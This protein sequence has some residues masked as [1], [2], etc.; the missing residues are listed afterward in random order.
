MSRWFAHAGARRTK[1]VEPVL[2]AR[3]R[4]ARS[5]V[6]VCL[7]ALGCPLLVAASAEAGQLGVFPRFA[8]AKAVEKDCAA[9]LGE[10]GVLQRQLA[11]GARLPANAGAD[12]AARHAAKLFGEMDR[13][14]QRAE[15][16]VAPLSLL[17]NVHPSKPLRDAAE[18]CELR[19]S[20]FS[21]RFYQDPKIYARIRQA[22]AGDDIDQRMRRDLLE[23]F[24]DSG[25]ALAPARR[26]RAR[27]LNNR[28]A[29]LSQ[30]FERRLRESSTRVAFTEAELQ[31]VPASVWRQAPRDRAGRRLL[32]LEYPSVMPVLENARDPLARERMWRA[33][34]ARGGEANLALLAQLAARRHEY[35]QL[36][37]LPSYADFALRHRMAG[38]VARAQGFLAEVRTVVEQRERRDLEDLR[39]AKAAEL[40]QPLEAS[41]LHRWDTAYYVERVQRERFALDMESFRR[42]FPAEAS[43]AFVMALSGRLFDIGFRPLEQP[44]WHADARA[45]EVFD[46]GDRRVLATLYLDLYPRADKFGHAAMWPVRGSSTASGRLPVAALVTNFSREGLT[47]QE[48]ETLLHEFG[49]ALHGMLS[50][51]RYATQAGT[52]VKLDFVEAPSQMLEEWVY[53]AKVLALFKEVCA[54]C[55]PVPADLLRRAQEARSFAKGLRFARQHL[56][57]SY[58]LAL[59]AAG[60]PEPMRLW[61]RLEGATPLGHEKGS[62]F[63]ASFAHI[64]GGYAAGYYAYLWSE[65]TA[66]D[67]HTAFADDH[68]SVA[69]GKRLRDVVLANGSQVDANELVTRFL[70]RKP[71]NAAFFDWLGR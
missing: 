34:N 46:L 20:A 48:L 28:I 22:Q 56:F 8:D 63:P 62:R 29:K 10:L 33:F 53:D 65:A 32:G 43:V 14:A 26:E 11:A 38:S 24:E 13:F 23:G 51:T 25:V 45:Y 41:R 7:A 35:A 16:T 58:D 6:G 9:M 61:A 55:E 39:A 50:N 19:Y 5:L 3:T 21:S 60:S 69:A 47:L 59:Y 42:H 66:H 15:D 68:L 17:A 30:D 2:P 36:F 70:G 31:G 71:N 44:L 37:G 18:A 57:A 4:Y 40:G 12:E 27:A 64:A 54:G 1:P 49:H 52:S 67:L